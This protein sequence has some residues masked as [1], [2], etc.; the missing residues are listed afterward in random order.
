MLHVPV[1][2]LSLVLCAKTSPYQCVRYESSYPVSMKKYLTNE[3][4]LITIHSAEPTAHAS[5]PRLASLARNDFPLASWLNSW[6]PRSPR[7]STFKP[8]LNMWHT[9]WNPSLCGTPFSSPSSCSEYGGLR[10]CLS[11]AKLGICIPLGFGCWR[12]DGRRKRGVR[13]PLQQPP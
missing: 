3:I 8:N 7:P 11:I 10:T 2:R 6:L 5:S 12:Q 1:T 4:L 13:T 9:S